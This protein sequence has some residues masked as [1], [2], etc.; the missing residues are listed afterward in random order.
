MFEEIT[1]IVDGALDEEATFMDETVEMEYLRNLVSELRADGVSDFQVYRITHDH[2]PF[3]DGEDMCVQYLT[4]HHP[5]F[6]QD[7]AE[8]WLGIDS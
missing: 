6:D 1:V 7:T 3:D 8:S 4:D 2:E 5:L